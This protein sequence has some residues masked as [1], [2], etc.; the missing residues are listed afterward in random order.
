MFCCTHDKCR[1]CKDHHYQ[2]CQLKKF[3]EI[4]IQHSSYLTEGR[5]KN[6]VEMTAAVSTSHAPLLSLMLEHVL[7]EVAGMSVGGV[8]D[9]TV[10][11]GTA[12]STGVQTSSGQGILTI[13]EVFL[14]VLF[15]VSLVSVGG[16][17]HGADV[18]PV[19]WSEGCHDD[20]VQVVSHQ[21]LVLLVT[22]HVLPDNIKKLIDNLYI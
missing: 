2:L 8:T 22:G 1:S 13:L 15:E 6:T 3:H 9:V 4:I 18:A 12:G 19:L 14:N 21:L 11:A 10:V 5:L 16:V 17:T 7:L 20:L